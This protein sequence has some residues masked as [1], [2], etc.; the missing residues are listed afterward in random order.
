MT[1]ENRQKK[2]KVCKHNFFCSHLNIYIKI[3]STSET[4]NLVFFSWRC[5]VEECDCGIQKPAIKHTAAHTGERPVELLDIFITS[6]R[7]FW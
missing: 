3:E 2:K 7:N 5:I 1:L 6:A 4:D